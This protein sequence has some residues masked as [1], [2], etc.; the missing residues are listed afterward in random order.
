MNWSKYAEKKGKTAD[1]AKKEREISPA[2][3]EIKNEAGEI[4]QAKKDA[5]KE[6]YIVCA[7]K[8]WDSETGEAMPDNETQY[9]LGQLEQEKKRW[10]DKMA[11]AKAYSDGLALA[12][13]DYKKL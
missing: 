7:C 12:I 9:S 13:E 6:S 10:D 11:E 2:K 4:V 8:H 1:F 5:V 3:K